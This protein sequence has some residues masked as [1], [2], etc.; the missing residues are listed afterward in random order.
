MATGHEREGGGGV[1][2]GGRGG[3]QLRTLKHEGKAGGGFAFSQK[4]EQWREG[5]RV[6]QACYHVFTTTFYLL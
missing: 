1:G 5:E 3:W 2:G 4:F 6:H